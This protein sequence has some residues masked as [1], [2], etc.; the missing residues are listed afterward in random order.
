MSYTVVVFFMASLLFLTINCDEEQNGSQRL[1]IFLRTDRDFRPL[2]FGKRN[3]FRPLQFGK[4]NDFRPLQFGKRS[5][6]YV[7]PIPFYSSKYLDENY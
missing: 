4:K 1:P 7:Y 3:N 2:Q 5:G 6:D